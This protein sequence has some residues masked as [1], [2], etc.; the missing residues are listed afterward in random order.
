[1]DISPNV[2]NNQ[3]TIHRPYKAQKKEDQNVDASVHFR[4]VNT[5]LTGGNMETKCGEETEG[6][7]IQRLPHLGIHPIYSHQ[8]WMFLWMLG[9]AC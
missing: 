7:A 3:D 6:K 2:L 9:S 8:T 1:V 4:R 5:I